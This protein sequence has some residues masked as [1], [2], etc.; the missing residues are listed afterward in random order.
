[1]NEFR[2]RQAAGSACLV[3]AIQKVS[4]VRLTFFIS[5]IGLIEQMKRSSVEPDD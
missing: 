3:Q 1:M 2:D 5:V 4:A